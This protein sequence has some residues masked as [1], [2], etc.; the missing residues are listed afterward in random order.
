MS[1]SRETTPP[2]RPGFLAGLWLGALLGASA[3]LLFTPDPGAQTRRRLEGTSRRLVRGMR[4][5]SRDMRSGLSDLAA[6]SRPGGG[7]RRPAPGHLEGR[8]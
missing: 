6:R 1:T 2:A 4:G 7:P 8:G 3:A 5:M